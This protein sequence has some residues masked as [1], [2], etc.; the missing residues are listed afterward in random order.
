MTPASGMTMEIGGMRVPRMLYGTAWKEERTAG[1][2]AMAIERGF[3]GIDTANQRRHYHESAV[4]EA[5][6]VVLKDRMLA[7]NE[8]FIQT[9][10]THPAGQDHR[11]PY[12]AKASTATQVRQ[13]F[14][15]SQQHL[16]VAV[17]DS[18]L[19]HGPTSRRGWSIEDREAWT[20]MESLQMSGE[21]R[22]I[23][24]SNVTA[25]QLDELCS[26]AMVRPSFVQNRCFAR[27]GWDGEMRNM[28]AT[29]GVVYQGFSLLTANQ[30]EMASVT[31]TGIAARHARTPAQ[32]IFR[33]ALD[34]GMIV[35]TG[36]TDPDHMSEDL[37]VGDFELTGPEREA[38]EH[39][40]G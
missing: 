32:V 38:I 21:V 20:A 27:T 19:L 17:I 31:V 6:G 13:S 23:G 4:G 5:L 10:F 1:L 14:E 30:R 2:V 39:V 37:S 8:L 9:K 11:R 34:L 18:L 16:G 29:H 40:S 35:L 3:R 7:R 26:F 22:L 24:V 33:F 15:S 25:S 12:D 28:C 36:T